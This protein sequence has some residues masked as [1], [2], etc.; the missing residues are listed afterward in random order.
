M[1]VIDVIPL[2]M[3]PRNQGETL[4]YF[5]DTDIPKGLIVEIPIGTRKV[6]AVVTSSAD[7]RR[8]KLDLRKTISFQIKK[9]IGIKKEFGVVSDWQIGLARKIAEYYYAPLGL[10]IKSVLPPFLGKKKYPLHEHAIDAKK[11]MP[12][13]LHA[14]SHN[15]YR[16]IIESTINDNNQILILVAEQSIAR[17]YEDTYKEF[18]PLIITSNISDNAYYKA[19]NTIASGDT[20][21][22]IGTKSALFLPF[23]NLAHIIID[24]ETSDAYRSEQMPR[25]NAV[26]VAFITAQL[27][28]AEITVS[29]IIPSLELY[30]LYEFK[31]PKANAIDIVD[32]AQEIRDKHYS[33]FSRP[34]E[35]LIRESITKNEHLLLYVPRKG[36]AVSLICDR[37][38][39]SVG[40]PH[41]E[42]SLVLH[43]APAEILRC[44]HC[45]YTEQIPKSCSHCKSYIL[46]PKG[47]GI[48]RIHE[49]LEKFIYYQNLKKTPI[50]QLDSESTKNQTQEEEIIQKFKEE[51]PA[52][53]LATQSIFSYKN[54]LKFENAGIINAD[55]LVHIPDFRSEERLLRQLGII[56]SMTSTIVLQ[57]YNPENRALISVSQDSEK[58]FL[59]KELEVRKLLNYPPFYKLI[60]LTLRHKDSRKAS[61]LANELHANLEK[62]VHQL[63]IDATLHEPMPNFIRKEKDYYQ[64][65]I[66][67]KH[68]RIS[69]EKRNM[70]LQ[71]VPTQ[72]LIEIDPKIAI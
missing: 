70:L 7:I 48:E 15:N 49:H 51:K 60:K 62:A 58:E 25:A 20:T 68:G 50:F 57:T 9:I 10:T 13:A 24:D 18:T 65:H 45:G 72:W 21:L 56:K 4:S 12:L 47:A 11:N 52:I 30:S 27:H 61:I 64:W 22:I 69:L 67:I 16:E 32:M 6:L 26:A 63:S 43:K 55:A 5:F 23:K 34:L 71:I 46:R 59:E 41:C 17:D 28:N 14:Q 54:L 53:I 3:I 33:F 44:H 38:G 8:K 66:L 40:C 36:H 42:I 37:C 39:K 1:F 19:W 2:A 29:S 31:A 35:R